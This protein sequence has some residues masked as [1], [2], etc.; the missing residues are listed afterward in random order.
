MYKV[1]QH[2]FLF[3]K[4]NKSMSL[5]RILNFFYNVSRLCIPYVLFYTVFKKPN[6]GGEASYC[7]YTEQDDFSFLAF[8]MDP[9]LIAAKI[10]TISAWMLPFRF[11]RVFDG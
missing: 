7:P 5:I 10:L 8:A 2:R 1:R 9:Y 4:C 3:S 11:C 6:Q